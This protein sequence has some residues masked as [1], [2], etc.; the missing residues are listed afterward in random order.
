MSHIEFIF[1]KLFYIAQYIDIKIS[2]RKV[3]KQPPP[4]SC[5]LTI[6]KILEK[7]SIERDYHVISS[8]IDVNPPFP[9]YPIS[10][11]WL[12]K[13]LSWHKSSCLFASS[14]T[15]YIVCVLFSEHENCPI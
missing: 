15:L 5:S 9:L 6:R 2:G 10:P 7:C 4:F 11:Y 1:K 8:S 3:F 13:L 12:E 14:C